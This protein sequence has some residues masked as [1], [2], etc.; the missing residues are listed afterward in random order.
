MTK[1]ISENNKY[2]LLILFVSLFF[3]LVHWTYQ[4]YLYND[5]I[6][7]KI[8]FSKNTEGQ[9]YS[10]IKFLSSLQF[11]QSYYAGIDN[12]NNIPI[13]VGSLVF[14]S[15]FFKVFGDIGLVIIDFFGIYIFLLIFFFLFK[16]TINSSYAIFFSI[17]L[18]TLP[19]IIE[20][21]FGNSFVYLTQLS[22]DFFNLRV[23]RPFPS[24]L[25]FFGF[26]LF[27][28][29]MQNKNFSEKKYF[30]ISG[31]ILA[32]QFSSFYY[33]FLISSIAFL[34]ILLINN[35]KQFLNFLIKNYTKFILLFLTFCIISSPFIYFIFTA[36]QDIIIASGIFELTLDKRIELLKY[37]FK[38]FLD[39]KFIIFN[40][41]ILI[42][43]L[44]TNFYLKESKNLIN[45]I[46]IFYISSIIAPIIFFSISNKSGLIYHFSNSILL[47][48]YLNL[49]IFSF[50]LFYNFTRLY[51]KNYFV[52]FLLTATLTFFFYCENMK[53]FNNDKNIKK[54]IR[55]EFQEVTDILDKSKSMNEAG[56]SLM[57]FDMFFMDWSII[58]NKFENLNLVYSTLTP[59]T[60]KEIERN[61]IQTFYFLELNS[62]D[63]LEYLQNKK[64]GFRYYNENVQKFMYMKY[65]AN[66]L[67]RFNNSLNFDKQIKNHIMS[68]S[69]LI[70]KQL[71]IPNEEIDRLYKK[72]NSINLNGFIDPKVIILDKNDEIYDK[73]NIDDNLYCIIFSKKI[74]E[75]YIKKNKNNK[76]E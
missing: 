11:N 63:F 69:P 61:L 30:L 5:D 47:L 55:A 72:F 26:I 24:S 48:G 76:C 15:L 31:A 43:I 6:I 22:N 19:T 37:F 28:V 45:T 21:F 13:P 4:F 53:N 1:Y 56:Y 50:I 49:I 29:V 62:Q 16:K 36:E 10:Y 73:I 7:T 65:T 75:V 67:N 59:R 66:S 39:F 9:L 57:T 74:Y 70:S 40:I 42:S 2:Y 23:H 60:F 38:K 35:K 17:I 52:Y 54:L 46:Y 34:I 51:L 14:H 58:K 71:V 8:L 18:Y 12:L 25:Y 20:F 41:A 32:L 68:T 64:I 44:I 27:C 3:F 33:F